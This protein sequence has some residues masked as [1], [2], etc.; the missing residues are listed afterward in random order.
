MRSLYWQDTRAFINLLFLVTKRR[1]VV[2]NGDR[3]SEKDRRRGFGRDLGMAG[4]KVLT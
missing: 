3:F 1:A 4:S 2:L